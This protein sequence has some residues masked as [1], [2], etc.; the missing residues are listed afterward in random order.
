MT[1]TKK[2][3]KKEDSHILR[4]LRFLRS[5]GERAT[6]REQRPAQ[7]VAA[8]TGH[9]ACRGCSDFPAAACSRKGSPPALT[10]AHGGSQQFLGNPT[11]ATLT[12]RSRH[13]C[14]LEGADE[15]FIAPFQRDIFI[16]MPNPLHNSPRQDVKHKLIDWNCRGNLKQ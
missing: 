1:H 5:H 9:T 10:S 14:S 3:A 15:I 12:Q 13:M 6:N 8:K 16:T 11:T 7:Q 4:Y 2:C